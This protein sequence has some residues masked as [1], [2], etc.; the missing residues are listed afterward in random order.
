MSSELAE[1]V[2]EQ[3]MRDF[4]REMS[5]FKDE[6]SVF[7]DGMRRF[8]E[9]SE[10]DRKAMNKRW[11]DLADKM[12]TLVEDIVAPNMPGVQREFFGLVEPGLMAVRVRRRCRRCR[13]GSSVASAPS[14]PAVPDIFPKNPPP[15]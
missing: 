7:K 12:G 6:M 8:R 9:A 14:T 11:G 5:E 15:P 13:L 2:D 4:R 10:S 3:E 1:K